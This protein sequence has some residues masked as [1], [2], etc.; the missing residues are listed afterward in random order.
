[1]DCGA[2]IGDLKGERN[3]LESVW[4]AVSMRRRLA[5]GVGILMVN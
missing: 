4:E 1:M 3:G 2:L 5:A